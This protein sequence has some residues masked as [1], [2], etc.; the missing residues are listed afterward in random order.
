M[1]M[2]ESYTDSHI[3]FEEISVRYHVLMDDKIFNLMKR[4]K[5]VPKNLYN[6][7]NESKLFWE[8]IGE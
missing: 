7:L 1:S 6:I 2:K 4:Q 3:D 8:D 5:K